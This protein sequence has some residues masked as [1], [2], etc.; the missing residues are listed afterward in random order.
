MEKVQKTHHAALLQRLPFLQQATLRGQ[1]GPG[2]AAFL[3]YPTEALCALEDA[4]WET[5]TRLRLHLRRPECARDQLAAA[6]GHCCLQ[7]A[8]GAV[9]AAPLDDLGYHGATCQSGGGVVR[10]HGRLARRLGGLL[11]RWRH[12]LPL[13]E[14]RVPLWDR[15]RPGR[16]GETERAVLDLEF[17]DDD[18]R[19]W[20]DVSVRHP[21]AG[22]EAE[23]RVAARRDGEASRRGERDKHA[24]YPGERLTPVI[25]EAG[26]R[27][28]AEA[29]LWLKAE[30]RRLPDAEQ[31]RE[32]ARA[33][34]VLSCGLQ[35]ELARQLRAAAGLR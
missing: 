9:C 35:G 33:H 3:G 6:T 32:L 2:A 34:R 14:Q 18:G 11:R 29:R 20:L 7:N 8:S 25:L 22:T 5:A 19:R 31:A 26:G 15:P 12:E 23:Q 17:Q 4:H 24:R 30:V 28:G 1:A 16:P 10:R 27:L 13:Y 21:A